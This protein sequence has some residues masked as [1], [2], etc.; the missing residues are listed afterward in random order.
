MKWRWDQG[1]LLYFRYENICAIAKVLNSLDGISLATKDDL[2]RYPLEVGTGLPFAPSHYKVWRNYARVF[3]CAMLATNIDNKLI[4]SELCQNLASKDP[5]SADE[6]LNFVFSHF[7]YPYP[8]FEDYNSEQHRVFPFIAIIKFLISRKGVS[9]SLDDVFEYVIGNECTG[10]ENINYYRSLQKTSRIPLGDEKRQVRE[11]L[12]FMS[13]ASYIR[14]FDSQL[15]ID[16]DEYDSVLSV[17]T[18]C[19]SVNRDENGPMEFL[20]LA[21][22]SRYSK[23]P[24]LDVE[25]KDRGISEFSVKEG[26]KNF[27]SHQKIE[28]SPLLRDRYFKFHPNMECDACGIA[29]VHKYPWLVSNNILELHH[30]LPLSATLIINGTTTTMDD[31]KPLCPN[32]HRSVHVFYKIKLNEWDMPDFS[33]RSM[34]MDVYEMAKKEIVR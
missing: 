9:V 23:M 2:L 27:S 29:P 31:L 15:Y 13:Q 14:W 1:R 19:L 7:Q 4:V 12:V 32:C 6:Y 10:Q 24:I 30:I 22:F 11:M 17:L 20:Q 5:L 25:L 16:T 28:R 18:P 34:A 33:S 26:R 8:A 3:Q 21:S